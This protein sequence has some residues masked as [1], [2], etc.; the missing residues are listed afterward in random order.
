MRNTIERTYCCLEAFLLP[1]YVVLCTFT[2][3]SAKTK[4]KLVICIFTLVSAMTKDKLI[5]LFCYYVLLYHV[6]ALLCETIM[7]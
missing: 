5:E 3:G 6:I 2:L 4:D 1:Y 7:C